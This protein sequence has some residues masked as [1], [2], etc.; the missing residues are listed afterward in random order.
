M[1]S[2]KPMTT[3]EAAMWLGLKSNT[4]EV[5]RVYGKG[6]KFLKMGRAVRYRLEDLNAYLETSVKNSTS[7]YGKRKECCHG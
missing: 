1:A 6:P 3:K 7:E 4:L 5:W 2:T